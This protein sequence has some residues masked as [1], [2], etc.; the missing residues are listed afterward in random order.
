MQGAPSVEMRYIPDGYLKLRQEEDDR[1]RDHRVDLD[2][3]EL[4]R[5]RLERNIAGRNEL[6]D[7]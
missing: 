2:N 7:P 3:D 5:R 1:L 6:R 4:A